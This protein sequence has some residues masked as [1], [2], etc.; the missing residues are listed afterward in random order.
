VGWGKWLTGKEIEICGK[1]VTEKGCIGPRRSDS[2]ILSEIYRHSAMQPF[3]V[4]YQKYL[5]PSDYDTRFLT[6]GVDRLAAALTRRAPRCVIAFDG[7]G[8]F[9]FSTTYSRKGM[10]GVTANSARS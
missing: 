2:P 3:S 4:S 10:N 8:S 5:L 9:D 7:L 1:R 6:D